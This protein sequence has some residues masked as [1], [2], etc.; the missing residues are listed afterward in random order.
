MIMIFENAAF[1]PRKVSTIDIDFDKS[2]RHRLFMIVD[3]YKQEVDTHSD[4]ITVR[5][6]KDRLIKAI[7]EELGE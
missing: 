6:W 2:N 4:Y 1:D 7:N 3:G 5:K